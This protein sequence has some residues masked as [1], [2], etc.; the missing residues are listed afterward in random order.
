MAPDA[1]RAQDEID[2]AKSDA[3][4]PTTI[5]IACLGHRAYD[6]STAFIDIVTIAQQSSRERVSWGC[7]SFDEWL[8]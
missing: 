6:H 4:F 7:S 1:R 5:S 8:V 2:G 3:Q